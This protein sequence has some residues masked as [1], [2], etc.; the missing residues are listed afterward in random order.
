M[1][2]WGGTEKYHLSLS[3]TWKAIPISRP[4]HT[5]FLG[6]LRIHY[7]ISPNLF[8]IAEKRDLYYFLTCEK[9][10]LDHSLLLAR[11]TYNRTFLP[12]VFKTIE[13]NRQAKV[14]VDCK[15]GR[16][17][18][19]CP[20]GLWGSRASFE[21]LSRKI[22]FW[23]WSKSIGGGGGGW[24]GAERGWGMRFWALCEGWVVQFSATLRGWVT[25]F[26]TNY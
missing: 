18:M 24:A 25:L 1:V 22:L 3:S 13:K 14:H 15:E 21:T 23:D 6:K 9:R 20:T 10:E 17:R 5:F 11:N 4:T 16:K 19:T 8:F 26:F 12:F 2:V 7:L